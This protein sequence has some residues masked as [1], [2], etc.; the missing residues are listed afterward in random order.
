MKTHELKT[1]N[2][3]FTHVW[4]D[5]KRA[6]LRFNDRNYK[7]GDILMLREYMVNKG[8]YGGRVVRCLITDIVNNFDGLNEGWVMLSFMVL[9][10]T[11]EFN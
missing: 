2:P 9:S 8:M 11:N 4:E 10:K 1:V 5:K 6:D 7:V 3:Y